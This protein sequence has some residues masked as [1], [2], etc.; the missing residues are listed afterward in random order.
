MT[1]TDV[2]TALDADWAIPCEV[3]TQ[4]TATAE[5]IVYLGT[6]CDTAQRTRLW[7]SL[8]LNLLMQREGPIVCLHCGA[9]RASTK[10]CIRRFE[11]LNRRTP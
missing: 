10:D 11:P 5:W 3:Q 1:E 7:C 6:C 2:I 9:V 8:H 4:D